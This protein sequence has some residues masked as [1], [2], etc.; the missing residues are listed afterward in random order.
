MYNYYLVPLYILFVLFLPLESQTAT[1][2]EFSF[3]DPNQA[4]AF[5]ELSE[6]FRC[7]VCQNES[8][9]ASQAEL[10]RDLRRQIY[11]MM[12]AG[13][14]KRQIIEFLVAR[15]GDFVLYNPPLKP[16]TYFLWYGPFLLVIIAVFLGIQILRTQQGARHGELSI[17]EQA[18]LAAILND[19]SN[20]DSK[21]NSDSKLSLNAKSRNIPS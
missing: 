4:K 3:S 2:A 7:L 1:L 18:Q 16:A 20:L 12:Q 13:K 9:A 19:P 14:T 10:A 17:E 5:R 21:S 6:Q 8:I 15:Y 11:E